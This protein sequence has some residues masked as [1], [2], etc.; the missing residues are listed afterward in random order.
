MKQVSRRILTGG[1]IVGAYDPMPTDRPG[2]RTLTGGQIVDDEPDPDEPG[3]F[4]SLARGAYQGA[5]FGFG[6]EI[7][8]AL[9][10]A[11][12]DKTYQQARDEARSRNAAAEK[13]HPWGFGLGS[14]LGTAGTGLVT[15]G[16]AAGA[17]KLGTAGVAALS[18][19]EGALQAA[20]ASEAEDAGG[21]LQDAA[22][23][24]AVG[25]ILGGGLHKVLGHTVDTA[26][27]RRGKQLNELIGEGG[28]PT[29]KKR[30]GQATGVKEVGIR[31][32]E[33]AASTALAGSSDLESA[34]ALGPGAA[35][36]EKV[37]RSLGVNVIDSD[38]QFL[39]ALQKGKKQ[40]IAV[41]QARL[42]DLGRE[43]AP[44]YRDFDARTG[45]GV[46]LSTITEKL[47]AA[48][49]AARTDYRHN[50]ADAIDE[51]AEKFMDTVRR[52]LGVK[53]GEELPAGAVVPSADVRKFA[54]RLQQEATRSMGS[55]SETERFAVKKEVAQ[56]A[57]EIL[58]DHLDEV[59]K[60]AP[61]Q[62]KQV[63]RLRDLND[64]TFVYAS[65]K[66]ALEASAKTAHTRGPGLLGSLTSAG[67]PGLAGLAMSGGNPVGFA[68]GALGARAVQQVGSR[69][70]QA[71]TRQLAALVRAARAG[72]VTADMAI[73]AIKAGVPAATVN[74]IMS[75]AGQPYALAGGAAA[76]E[77]IGRAFEGRHGGDE[78][79]A[80]TE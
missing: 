54:T 15:G 45:G 38:P 20:G 73:S 64:K 29:V 77:G 14:V 39:G 4:E 23:G 66:E 62:A 47:E 79:E 60:M 61:G 9:E 11:F 35:A 40:A 34:R 58:D 25:G 44:L 71:A 43:I 21:V 78:A 37:E 12:T 48:S 56:T 52:R 32:G 2:R 67:L 26:V 16:L 65:A 18:A 30:L 1:Q 7:S 49:N 17:A 75:S 59:A 63:Q 5:S 36:G 41:A 57:K 46:P 22:V 70:N 28:V 80:E 76:L 53:E 68:A 24:G 13:A 51:H 27:E 8:G 55:L 33:N 50:V 10:S 3:L 42:D 74:T 19:G 31:E 6:D 72:S 69:V